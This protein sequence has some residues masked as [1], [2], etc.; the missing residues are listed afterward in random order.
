M[1]K[2]L[3]A[4][5]LVVAF[6]SIAC[7]QLQTG[8]PWP[9]VH[10]NLQNT[11]LG[12][13]SGNIGLLEWK[14]GTA[15]EH[16]SAPVIA[17]D[18]MLYYGDTFNGENILIA[19]TSAT[20][21]YEWSV[22]VGG[23][24]EG[25]PAIGSD[26]T[27]YFGANDNNLYAVSGTGTLKW[28]YATGGP[29]VGSPTIGADGTIYFG[30][31]DDSVYALTDN[32]ASPTKL[33]SYAT[34]GQVVATPAIAANGDVVIGSEDHNL[35][36]F[37]G[38]TGNVNIFFTAN[39][40]I[41]TDAV[42]DTNGN[43][44]FNTVNDA[45][46][47][48]E[49]AGTGGFFEDTSYTFFGPALGPD[50]TLY[51]PEN[52]SL[53]A[54]QNENAANESIF[55]Y[56]SSPA[57][58]VVGS[59]GTAYLASDKLYSL[60]ANFAQFSF[61]EHWSYPIQAN[62]QMAMDANGTLYM[63]DSVHGGIVAIGSSYILQ[64]SMDPEAIGGQY[65]NG[66]VLI[67]A[68]AFNASDAVTLSSNS[69]D[70]QIPPSLPPI[71]NGYQNFSLAT[72][73]VGAPET[74][75][76]TATCQTTSKQMTV[77]L[78]PSAIDNLSLASS[79]I[80]GGSTAKATITLDGATGSSGDVVSLTSS[81]TDANI[82]ASVTVANGSETA[83]FTFTPAAVSSTEQI[84]LTATLGPTSAQ[85]TLTLNPAVLAYLEL[86]P[87]SVQGGQ[88]TSLGVYLSGKAGSGG[89]VVSLT[90]S[91]TDAV[92]PSTLTVSQ[93]ATSG[94]VLVHTLPVSSK[95][96]VTLTATLGS[97]TWQS[98]LAL[99]PATLTGIRVAPTA[100]QGGTSAALAV[101]LNGEAG[102]S[103]DTV[104]LTSSSQDV[105]VPSSVKVNS[106]ATDA[107][108]A[109]TTSVVSSE[110]Q[111]TLSA[112]FGSTT[113]HAT[114]T[115]NPIGLSGLKLEYPAVIG[116]SPSALAVYLNTRA[117]TGG[118]LVN[119]YSS[120][121]AASLQSSVTIPAGASSANVVV[122]TAAVDSALQVTITAVSGSSSVSTTLTVNPAALSAIKL[123][124]STTSN[125]NTPL[126]FAVYLNGPA[127]PG[128][129]VVYLSH[130]G[131]ALIY[132]T[133]TVPAGATSANITVYFASSGTIT[134]TLESVT[135]QTQVTYTGPS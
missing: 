16:C 79:S 96:L 87:T 129:A 60:S 1:I 112:T 102:A 108:V 103:G 104:S 127:G 45:Y 106:G 105:T 114:I 64:A 66:T 14:L 2:R 25:S 89:D 54:L 88:R 18:G 67:A 109:V 40:P 3:F 8:S 132:S 69:P 32:G 15:I 111:V 92:L 125:A 82:P 68:G 107:N 44:L 90:S 93:G 56:N 49:T 121:T 81:S 46:S 91:S 20:G 13:G 12:L 11:G 7:A 131:D 50:G 39:G 99:L 43:V 28:T 10:G 94:S 5:I 119:L 34:G 78:D 4:L 135:L 123:A 128:G 100:L 59:D 51:L 21:V 9:K 72:S 124:P 58:M 48:A 19:V 122:H 52:V 101:Y 33:W 35:Y 113:L 130:T 27:I 65:V 53:L 31:E 97:S 24:I 26:G 76:V 77:T 84:T 61:T 63:P 83:S 115:L 41:T 133:I 37:N 38:A 98:T 30:S 117:G 55:G 85:T 73:V 23:Q 70:V 86:A 62:A 120:S 36:I 118:V 126:K 110:E 74:V 134:A 95:E 22:T 6:A 57:T 29:I 47:I 75:T 17:A 80:Q 42:L 71:V 116:G